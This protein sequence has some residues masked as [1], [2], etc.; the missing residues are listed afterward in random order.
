MNKMYAD[1][2]SSLL[3]CTLLFFKLTTHLSTTGSYLL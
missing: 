2:D 1:F 3:E